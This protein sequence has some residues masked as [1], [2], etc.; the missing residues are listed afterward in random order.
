MTMPAMP[1]MPG[2]GGNSGD[3][4]NWGQLMKES[5]GAAEPLPN[6]DYDCKVTRAEAAKTSNGKLMFKLTFEVIAG[7]HT[8]RKIWGNQTVSPENPTALGIFFSQ[9]KALGL[10]ANFFG[11]QPSP[12][13]VAGAM[14]GRFARV[15]V[16]QRTWQGQLRNEVKS[17]KPAVITSDQG[18]AAPQVA[19]PAPVA[20]P[21]P[22]PQPAPVQPAAPAPTPPPAPVAQAQPP[23]AP[24]APAPAPVAPTP[25]PEASQ[26]PPAAP[27][28]PPV[29]EQ[30]TAPAPAPAPA[31]Q[32]Q[33]AA[34]QPAPAPV[35]S[36]V[37]APP[38]IPF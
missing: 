32:P 24:P 12:G 17:I 38:P 9:M 15:N 20:V 30:Q 29:Q 22:Q 19:A 27:A 34:P 4:I 21:A 23:V 26:A 2:A 8:R 31:P 25:A 1:A 7:P 37:P 10:D 3:T 36:S 5:G 13:Q 35:G 11:A 33:P 28:A 18:F 14:E 16:G 6:G